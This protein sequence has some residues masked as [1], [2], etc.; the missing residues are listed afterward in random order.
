MNTLLKKSIIVLIIAL[1]FSSFATQLVKAGGPYFVYDYSSGGSGIFTWI[2]GPAGNHYNG[3]SCELYHCWFQG[4]AADGNVSVAWWLP[5]LNNVHKW[6]AHQSSM[7]QAAVKYIS[8][9]ERSNGVGVNWT[10]IVNQANKNWWH[11]Y[12]YL[13]YNDI[14]PNQNAKMSLSN[15]CVP[16]Y[17]CFSSLKVYWDDNYYTTSP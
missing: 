2:Y 15:S 9:Y 14:L 13:G 17:S 5:N 16:G 10:V 4:L 12:V 6:Y 3:P 1:L 8:T 11:I 7:G